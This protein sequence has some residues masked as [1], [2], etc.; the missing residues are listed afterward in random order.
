MKRFVKK[1]SGFTLI[2][3]VIYGGLLGIL[4]VILSDYFISI[5]NLQLQTKVSSS[6][7]Q[8]GEYILARTAYD[9]HRALSIQ[10]PGVGITGS[11]VSIVIHENDVDKTYQYDV[12]NGNL[13]LTVDSAATQLN[14]GESEVAGFSV[15]RIGNS[16]SIVGA[17]DTLRM[18][19]TLRSKA[20]GSSFSERPFM[21]TVS[22]R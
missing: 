3:L 15:F 8:D 1:T 17:K 18:S 19:F 21:T 13:M 16:D 10:S 22:L 6:I 9:M 7:E 5:M 4:L 14:S 11:S 2:E 12:Q 20:T